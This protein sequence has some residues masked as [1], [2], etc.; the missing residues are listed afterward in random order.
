MKLKNQHRIDFLKGLHLSTFCMLCVH[1]SHCIILYSIYTIL[2]SYCQVSSFSLPLKIFLCY[3]I[4]S[5]FLKVN[6]QDFILNLDVS[7]D[8]REWLSTN[9]QNMNADVSQ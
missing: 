9:M 1:V 3:K 4:K 2:K 8:F 7:F 6:I 5:F